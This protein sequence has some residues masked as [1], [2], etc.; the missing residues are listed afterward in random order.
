M[1]LAAKIR[2]RWLVGAAFAVGGVVLL[3]SVSYKTS[4]TVGATGVGRGLA[5]LGLGVVMYQLY[6]R[7]RDRALR[8][9]GLGATVA[10]VALFDLI[11]SATFVFRHQYL[12]VTVVAAVAVFMLAVPATGP[13][14]AIF[15]TPVM[16]WLGSRSFA[17]YALHMPIIMA[18]RGLGLVLHTPRATWLMWVT[19]IGVPLA[20]LFAADLGHRY[21]ERRWERRPAVVTRP[22]EHPMMEQLDSIVVFVPRPHTDDVVAALLAFETVDG[23]RPH[24]AFVSEGRAPVA[25]PVTTADGP[26]GD[27]AT[28]AEPEDR[29][30]VTYPRYRRNEVVAAM[31]EVHPSGEPVYHV[32]EHATVL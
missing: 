5:G 32:V 30:E 8:W 21:I 17:L 4:N 31:R 14:H 15:S 6:V 26:A 12:P 23:S 24:R 7:Y 1:V 2:A 27:V 3:M 20:A 29:V 18:V 22:A 10:I 9:A 11:L 16:R 13:M 19:G 25:G 28:A